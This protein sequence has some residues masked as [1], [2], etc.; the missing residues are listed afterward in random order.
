MAA[1]R[2]P[3]AWKRGKPGFPAN[4]RQYR[5]RRIV[6]IPYPA[7]IRPARP[8]VTMSVSPEA[9][10][11][12]LPSR[13]VPSAQRIGYLETVLRQRYKMTWEGLLFLGLIVVLGFTALQSGTNLLYLMFA[14]LIAFFL[15]QGVLLNI[16][17][18]RL[19]VTRHLPPMATAG[20]PITLTHTVV[21]RKAVFG[22]AA[23][24]VSD[25]LA[26][27]RIISARAVP[28]VSRRGEALVRSSVVFPH[29]GL[30]RLT[31]IELGS[32]FPFGLNERA[33]LFAVPGEILVLPPVLEFEGATLEVTDL[34]GDQP[35]AGKGAGIDFYGLRPYREGDSAR[36]VHWRTSARQGRLMILER[37]QDELHEVVL[38][39]PTVIAPDEDTVRTA[40][41]FEMAILMTASLAHQYCHAEVE[42]TLATQDGRVDAGSGPGH[43]QRI[44]RALALVELHVSDTP[45]EWPIPSGLLTGQ[46]SLALHFADSHRFPA[47]AAATHVDAREWVVRA[48]RL[49]H[50][51]TR[52]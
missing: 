39:L 32:R 19:S 43:V 49:K 47:G 12:P 10:A 46:Q 45:P 52:A 9:V 42:V 1:G 37:H 2:G 35:A 36:N 22:S 26:G 11:P 21:N 23:L 20:E 6:T 16:N 38:F 41:D 31:D 13:T 17:L 7:A 15:A 30:C 48:G 8:K 27:G 33:M 4:R 18:S 50:R 14:V 24:R 25:C 28:F 3:E 40:Q 29:R 5:C 34:F 51:G 44:L